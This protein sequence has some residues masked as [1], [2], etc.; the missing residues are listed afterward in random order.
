M[1]TEIEIRKADNES[2]DTGKDIDI[3]FKMNAMTT[4]TSLTEDEVV[5]LVSKIIN[6]WS[7]QQIKNHIEY[8]EIIRDNIIS[9]S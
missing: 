4:V 8:A 3:L 9:C 1:K 7:P 6:Q 5:D 2:F